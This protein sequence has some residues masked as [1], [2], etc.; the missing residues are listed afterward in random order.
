MQQIK[1]VYVV[2]KTHLDVGFTDLAKNVVDKYVNSFIPKAIDLAY[3]VNKDGENKRFIWTVGSW[4]VDEYLRRSDYDAKQKLIG[5]INS[6][7]ITWSGLPFTTHSELMDEELFNFGISISKDLDKLFSKKTIAAK[8]TDVP[9]HTRGI[10]EP[11]IRNGI[12]YLHI[13]VN[14]VSHKPN[15][16]D[17]FIWK[18]SK[19]NEIIVDYCQGYG[20][21]TLVPGL[22]AV[23]VFAHSGDNLGPPSKEEI[24]RQFNDIQKQFP[25]A[26]VKASTLDNYANEVIKIRDT[27]PIVTD[28]IGDTW[29]HG[30]ASDPYKVS[31]YLEI[32]RLKDKWIQEGKLQRDTQV[33]KEFL[34][35]LLMIPEHT[36]GLDFKKY[37]SD[38]KNWSKQDFIKARQIDKLSETYI[39]N[40]YSRYG[41]YAK[42]EFDGQ[43]KNMKWEERSY[44]YYESSHEEQREYINSAIK[45]LPV[46]LKEGANKAIS[47]LNKPPEIDKNSS[48]L[49]IGKEYIVNG[50]SI[51]ILKDASI[52]VK[53]KGIVSDVSLG[54][55]SYE[56]FGTNVFEKWEKEYMV[57][58]QENK[59]WAMPDFFKLGME[60]VQTTKEN[61]YFAPKA[62]IALIYKNTI[63]IRA[64][65]QNY[66]C[67]KY[68]SPRK[69][70]IKYVF[71]EKEIDVT[72]Y[73]YNKDA[74]RIPE[75][76]WIS[77][78]EDNNS[79]KNIKIKKLEEIIDPF[80]IVENGNR[81]NH[82]IKEVDL[83]IDNLCVKVIP[84]DS[85]LIS[86]GEK[87]LYN[88]DQNYAE[89]KGGLHFNLYNNLWG[90]NFKMWYED[91][92]ISR[93]KIKIQ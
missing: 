36:W 49:L 5:A 4:L 40:K 3:Q 60:D 45:S 74:S 57:N 69:I 13:G 47:N 20:K 33:Y 16:P 54:K 84:L 29:I 77:H 80:K 67:D 12:E 68:G 41:N 19:G 26:E 23:L 89:L 22:E 43:V 86:I 2:Y 14:D 10:I 9:G 82:A 88:F 48:E 55:I 73:L 18:D 76:L 65:F 21:T 46:E 62:E 61:I 93:F 75:A 92:I 27:L 87:R 53:G 28:E 38:Y 51:I 70:L 91:D 78:F 24:N 83:N 35:S 11:L 7:Y 63:T 44:S 34:R 6:G 37:L 56:I 90:T 17:T 15:V 8:M 31:C 52:K 25:G 50:F 42:A 30:I 58:L 59:L 66:E 71:N 39:P 72:T 85:T 79:I 64:N 32:L 1:R 81:N